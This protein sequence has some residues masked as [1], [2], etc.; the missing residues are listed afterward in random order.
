M[1]IG[2]GFTTKG[3]DRAITGLASLPQDILQQT[4]L[5]VVGEDAKSPTKRHLSLAKRLSVREQSYFFLGG[6]PREQI[7]ALLAAGDL[8]VHPAYGE[9]TGTVLLEAITAGLPVLTTDTLRLRTTHRSSK[10]WHRVG[11]SL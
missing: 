6:R 2:S 4:T 11:L 3:L 8:M 5:T 9:N 10:C 7:P 1:F